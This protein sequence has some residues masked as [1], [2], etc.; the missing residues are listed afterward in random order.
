MNAH[1]NIDKLRGTNVFEARPPF[2]DQRLSPFG[3]A[4]KVTE[5]PLEQ[6]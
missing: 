2:A 1:L 3:C 6:L 5:S 4:T